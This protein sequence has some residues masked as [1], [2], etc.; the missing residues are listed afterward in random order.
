MT[1][2]RRITSLALAAALIICVACPWAAAETGASVVKGDEMTIVNANDVDE[3]DISTG[4]EKA[5]VRIFVSESSSQELLETNAA[6]MLV[7]NVITFY[8]SR[9]V[10]G[11]KNNGITAIVSDRSVVSLTQDTREGSPTEGQMTATPLSA[12]TCTVTFRNVLDSGK[13]G[14]VRLVLTFTVSYLPTESITIEPE[15]LSLKVGASQTLAAVVLPSAA[16]QNVTWSTSD[17]KIAT[18]G[19]KG[20]VKGISRG[21]AVI[22]CTTSD[23]IQAQCVVTVLPKKPDPESIVLNLQQ[24][25]LLKGKTK[26]LTATILPSDAKKD[27][28]WSTSD[29]T[30]AKV[31]KK[32][33][34]TGV[35]PGT[36]TITCTAV[37]GGLTV[38]SEVTVI[39]SYAPVESLTLDSEAITIQKGSKQKLTA[40]VLPADANQNVTWSTS[41]KKI[42]K[43][44]SNGMVTGV[45]AG[46]ATITCKTKQGGIIATCTVTV[47]PKS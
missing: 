17:K 25:S 5:I 9:E 46:T 32:G 2:L 45:K 24:F 26:T 4:A 43:V 8:I 29:K 41:N 16:D 44:N 20:V 40:S 38:T 23:G 11:N 37:Q 1:L 13:Y 19:A 15:E 34:V 39:A 36:A 35:N 33:V 7:G 47:T 21:E 10:S 14:N 3:E 42:A 18:V 31:N 30:V 22:T 12:G 6:S 28:T 27:V